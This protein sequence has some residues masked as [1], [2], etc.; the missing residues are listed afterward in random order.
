MLNTTQQ[1][2][3]EQIFVVDRPLGPQRPPGITTIE[4]PCKA[5]AAFLQDPRAIAGEH[6]KIKIK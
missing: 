2:A 1:E 3:L 6:G 4:E 5:R